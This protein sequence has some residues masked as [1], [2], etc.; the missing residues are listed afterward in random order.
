MNWKA[1]RV[2]VTGGAS[3][4]GS[5]LTDALVARGARVRIVDDL[6][7]GRLENLQEP[8][9]HN[10]IE[11]IRADLLKPGAAQRAVEAM[12]VVFHLAA[13]HGGRGYLEMHQAACA[14]NLA[15]DGVLFKACQE[16]GVK[17]VVYASSGCVYPNFLQTNPH[18]ISYL[19]EDKV[20]PPYD[21]DNLYGWAELIGEMTLR[22]YYHD[23]GMKSGSCRYFTVYGPREH[24]NHAV[25]AMIARSFVDQTPFVVWGNGEQICNWTHVDDIVRGTL[26]AAERVED[27]TAINLGTRE[28]TRVLDAVRE[29]LRYTGKEHLKVSLDRSMP[30]G[31]MH[32]VADPTLAKK[33]LD[34]EPKVPFLDA[35]GRRSTGITRRTIAV[36]WPP[37]W[38]VC[39]RSDRWAVKPLAPDA[40]API[41]ESSC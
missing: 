11:F 19:S 17:K 14:T 10:Q 13:N 30:T 20:G 28:R 22:A 7:S 26:A 16:A 8:L 32:R 25:I 39:S 1:H 18:E 3:F 4:I 41:S 38:T 15:L 2:L 33:L 37:R 24:H 21:A 12:D 6:S 36:K 34:W 27:G 9:R 5:H 31:P 35:C 40:V 23:T 29:V